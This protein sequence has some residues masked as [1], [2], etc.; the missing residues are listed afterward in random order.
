[1]YCKIP[2]TGTCTFLKPQVDVKV[3]YFKICISGSLTPLNNSWDSESGCHPYMTL[4]MIFFFLH[5]IVKKIVLKQWFSTSR[6]RTLPKVTRKIRVV[7]R[8]LNEYCTNFALHSCNSVQLRLDVFFK[9]KYE[10][11]TEPEFFFFW[12]HSS[13]L[14]KPTLTAMQLDHQELEIQVCLATSSYWASV[15]R[16]DMRS[17]L[18]TSGILT[19]F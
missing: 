17:R 5:S 7:V 2:L 12:L 9:R 16:A 15:A 3:F 6:S 13:F 11:Q 4:M 1:M 8:W 18:Q 10:N 19:S 14:S